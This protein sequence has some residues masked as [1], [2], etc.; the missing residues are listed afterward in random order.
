MK[1]NNTLTMKRK[2]GMTLLELT[3]VILVLLSL[4]SILFVGARA[5]KKGSDRSANIMNILRQAAFLSI[6][7]MGEF[8]VILV[9]NMD[10]S[11]T[12]TIGM[13][14]IF[15]AGFVVD[16]GMPLGLAIVLVLMMS[17]VVG[18][19]NFKAILHAWEAQKHDGVAAL[20]TFVTAGDLQGEELPFG[21]RLLRL[22]ADR[23]V[24]GGLSR[25]T[26]ARP[27]PYRHLARKPAAGPVA[28]AARPGQPAAALL[29]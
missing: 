8:F 4:I 1:L 25:M 7:A 3:V 22:S 11:I 13:S 17:A 2:A 12:S 16:G 29:Q 9:G 14:S 10:M 23:R 18:L 15:L 6:I 27:A 21:R 5:W 20:V 26:G 24:P 19:I 28:T